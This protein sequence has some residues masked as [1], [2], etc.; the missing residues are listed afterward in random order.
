[1]RPSFV[2]A[3]LSEFEQWRERE[4]NLVLDEEERARREEIRVESNRIAVSNLA[5]APRGIRNLLLETEGWRELRE[6]VTQAVERSQPYVGPEFEEVWEESESFE[7]F[8]REMHDANWAARMFGVK[9]PHSPIV[10]WK[11]VRRPR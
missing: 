2:K 3:E 4:R 7:H 8:T 11:K 6:E 9:E 1:V 5:R 10:E